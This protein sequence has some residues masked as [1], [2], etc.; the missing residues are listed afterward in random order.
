MRDIAFVTDKDSLDGEAQTEPGAETSV[1]R[2]V[3]GPASSLP[4]PAPEPAVDAASTAS[5]TEAMGNGGTAEQTP[6]DPPVA[7]VEAPDALISRIAAALAA[8]AVALDRT[9]TEASHVPREPDSV[10]PPAAERRPLIIEPVRESHPALEADAARPETAPAAETSM[11]SALQPLTPEVTVATPPILP[12]RPAVEPGPHV[13]PAFEP[14]PARTLDPI[15][16]EPAVSRTVTE[17]PLVFEHVASFD[18]RPETELRA[19][20]QPDSATSPSRR[21]RY[22]ANAKRALRYVSYAFAGYLALVLA[23]IPVY[24]FV[25][26]PA[27]TLMAWQW[28]TGKEVHQTWMPLGSISPHLVRAVVVAEDGRFCDHN[29]VDLLAME[30]AIE[31]AADGIPRGA[32]TISMQVTKNVFLWP[33]KSYLRKAIEIP[34]T[35][36]MELVWPKARILEVYLNVAEWGPGVFGAEAAARHHFN[37]SA[38]KLSEREAAQLAASLPNPV[39]RDAGEPGPRTQKKAAVIQ[40]RVRSAGG[41]VTGCISGQN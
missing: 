1:P 2:T 19:E 27:S 41:E 9:E 36:I 25:N 40:A 3:G 37:K 33:S 15:L 20:P 14:P 34:L 30:D 8:H 4:Q 32:S 10:P 22:W 26:P 24:R 31:K 16:P 28:L 23:L 7:P 17:S 6:A 39:R 38:A 12:E 35:L 18:V 29:G 11:P 13:A 5:A 21:E